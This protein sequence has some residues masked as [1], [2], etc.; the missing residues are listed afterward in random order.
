MKL[1]KAISQRLKYLIKENNISQYE[2]FKRTGLPQSTISTI[3][4]DKVEDIKISTIYQ[5]CIGFNIEFKD[6]FND[7]NFKLDNLDD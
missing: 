7:K 1:T 4:N 5:I 2:L 6:F 3:K